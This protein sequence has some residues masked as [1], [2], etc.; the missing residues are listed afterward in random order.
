MSKCLPN[1]WAV[2]ALSLFIVSCAEEESAPLKP[3][4]VKT[5]QVS[6]PSET[7][8]RSFSGQL[9]ASEGTGIGF[10][11]NG[12]ILDLDVKVGSRIEAEEV[13]ARL[14]DSDYQN[15]LA[16]ANAK[17]SQARKE[18]QRTRLLFEA[19]NASQSQIDSATARS[20]SAEAAAELAARRVTDCVLKMPYTGLIGEVRAEK[21]QVVSAGQVIVTIQ[22]EEG[23]EF[24]IGVPADLVGAIE[25]GQIVSIEVGGKDDLIYSGEV[26]E[27][28]P[29]VA[30]NTTYPVV[31]TIDQ[32]DGQIRAGMDGVAIVELPSG[33]A[34][35]MLIPFESVVAQAD[36]D[37]FVWVVEVLGNGL[38]KLGRQV[39]VLGSLAADGMIGV[40]SGLETGDV[41]VSRGVHRVE[42]GMEV[43]VDLEPSV[44]E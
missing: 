26:T 29:Q 28:S 15:Q 38:G 43:L 22:G 21:Q 18:L 31:I 35:L 3:R 20:L 19:E 5:F 42:A 40:V 41:I 37:P 13:L 25:N 39:V 9:K 10:Q 12:R 6:E 8:Q 36:N 44:A 33:T 32:A 16:D 14:D 24:E 4:V 11:V 34:S 1:G 2:F 17:L 23:L 7:Y 30:E 27:I